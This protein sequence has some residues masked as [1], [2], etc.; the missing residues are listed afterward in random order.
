[1]GPLTPVLTRISLIAHGFSS[2]QA[3]RTGLIC[4][5]YKYFLTNTTQFLKSTNRS[6]HCNKPLAVG[7]VQRSPLSSQCYG[8]S[9]ETEADQGIFR[10]VNVYLVVGS[11]AREI[12]IQSRTRGTRIVG[13]KGFVHS[14]S[15]LQEDTAKSRYF[16]TVLHKFLQLNWLTNYQQQNKGINPLTANKRE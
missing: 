15:D 3:V 11:K 9:T 7:P 14:G 12:K 10:V 2:H 5:L 16:Q 13:Q 8:R 6:F 1:M 4:P